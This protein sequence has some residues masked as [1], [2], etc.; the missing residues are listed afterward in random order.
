MRP[1]PA[2][3]AIMEAILYSTVFMIAVNVIG[4]AGSGKS[5]VAKYLHDRYDFEVHRPSD[6]LRDYAKRNQLPLRSRADYAAYHRIITDDD[7][8]AIIRPV[9]ESSAE[10]ICLD[11]LRVIALAQTLKH[12]IG[13]RTVALACPPEICFAHIKSAPD[14]RQY[15][16]ELKIET[17]D[18]YLA[19]IAADSGNLGPLEINVERVMGMADKVIRIGVETSLDHVL[20]DGVDPYI[21]ELLRAA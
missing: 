17:L 14:W 19:D 7:P 4:Q 18:D 1:N 2:C 5:S 6:V 11:G 9:L 13:M 12:Q 15:R 8:K 21:T 20:H 10:R 16:D 3:L